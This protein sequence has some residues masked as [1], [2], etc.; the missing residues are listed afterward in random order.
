MLRYTRASALFVLFS[1]L[2]AGL[3]ACGGNDDD[4]NGGGGPFPGSDDQSN[5][6]G[7]G[8]DDGGDGDDDDDEGETDLE[9]ALAFGDG[10]AVITVGGNRYEF[11]ATSSTIG[12]QTLVG[13]CRVLFGIIQ[14]VGYSAEDPSVTFEIEMPPTNWDTFED[15][16]Y[17]PPRIEVEVGDEHQWM[18]D[19]DDPLAA[20][21]SVDEWEIDDGR[22]SGTATFVDRL[23]SLAGGSPEPVQGTFEIACATE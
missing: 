20:G 21:S 17:D 3:A 13:V 7:E 6:D 22:A 9:E 23:I 14:G 11:S 4:D 2:L 19:V 5:G 16:R 18:A 1:L 12:G 8:D 10:M 15:N